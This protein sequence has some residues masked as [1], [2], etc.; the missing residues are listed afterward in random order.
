[1]VR[2]RYPLQSF[3]ASGTLNDVITYYTRFGLSYVRK[4]QTDPVSES[5]AQGLLRDVFK[6]AVVSAHQLTE[7]QKAHYHNLDPRSAACPWYNNFLGEYIKEFYVGVGV[8]I[9]SLQ[10]GTI[11]F[12]NEYTIYETISAVDKDYSLLLFMGQ[13]PG[14]GDFRSTY[15]RLGWS[16]NTTIFA[17]RGGIAHGLTVGYMVIEFSGLVK[18]VIHEQIICE[19][20]TDNTET[21]EGRALDRTLLFHNGCSSDFDDWGC[22]LSRIWLDNETTLHAKKVNFNGWTS[23]MIEVLEIPA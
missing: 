20:V 12:T 21:I 22:V 10:T 3:L 15:A 11:V 8:S 5:A 23:T 2:L 19:G 4:K 9:K 14:D 17:N 16:N 18:K 6:D 7:G 13:A 1:M